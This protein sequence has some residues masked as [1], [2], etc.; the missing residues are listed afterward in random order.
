MNKRKQNLKMWKKYNQTQCLQGMS[1]QAGRGRSNTYSGNLI[2]S[3]VCSK[4]TMTMTMPSTI[5]K[6]DRG[7]NDDQTPH[8][9][10]TPP[11]KKKDSKNCPKILTGRQYI[12]PLNFI[13]IF[14]SGVEKAGTLQRNRGR[15]SPGPRLST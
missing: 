11:K 7:Q 14:F 1:I 10:S 3:V 8:L 9:S 15:L 13:G 12:N 4:Q 5:G 2:I 6:L